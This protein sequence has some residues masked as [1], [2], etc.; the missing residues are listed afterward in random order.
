VGYCCFGEEARVPGVFEEP[1]VLDVGYGMR[2]DLMGQGSGHEFIRSILNFAARLFSP[3]RFRLLILDW[4][5]RSRAA[6]RSAGFEEGGTVESTE[7]TFVVMTR[8]AKATSV[9]TDR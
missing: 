5:A 8:D 7:G 1:G 6:A 4:N 3:P 9:Q 2:P